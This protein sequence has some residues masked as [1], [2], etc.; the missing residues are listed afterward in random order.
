MIN[1]K[2]P[3]FK[4]NH[5]SGTVEVT[6]P[7]KVTKKRYTVSMPKI[8]FERFFE[9]GLHAPLACPSLSR[10]DHEFINTGTSPE[11][12]TNIRNLYGKDGDQEDD[13]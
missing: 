10:E 5:N 8:E 1:L 2:S 7:C 12:F 6:G 13:D 11:G 3:L 9:D 4:V